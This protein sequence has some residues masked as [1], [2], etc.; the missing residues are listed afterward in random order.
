MWCEVRE[1]GCEGGV[2][3]ERGQGEKGATSSACQ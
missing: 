2:N 1:R 3:E